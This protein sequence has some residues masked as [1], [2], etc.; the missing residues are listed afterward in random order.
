[1][2]IRKFSES[3]PPFESINFKKVIQANEKL[4]DLMIKF[5]DKFD[6]QEAKFDEERKRHVKIDK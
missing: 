5:G 4:A 1:M 6:K 2:E 3:K